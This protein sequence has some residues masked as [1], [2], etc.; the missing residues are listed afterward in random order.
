MA[1]PYLPRDIFLVPCLVCVDLRV[2][3]NSTHD[4]CASR[5]ASMVS[6]L[7]LL[8]TQLHLSV[9]GGQVVEFS[10]VVAS[11]PRPS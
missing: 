1:Q 2:S 11:H 3:R 7:L 4:R 8:K 6:V 10:Q 5:P 9:H